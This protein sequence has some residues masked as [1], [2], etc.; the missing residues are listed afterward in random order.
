MCLSM[1]PARLL[2]NS[3]SNAPCLDPF[4]ETNEVGFLLVPVVSRTEDRSLFVQGR[5]IVGA[6]IRPTF[7]EPSR[8]LGARVRSRALSDRAADKFPNLAVAPGN[9]VSAHT[10]PPVPG[11]PRRIQV[12]GA[13]LHGP[14]AQPHP[15]GLNAIAPF[16][17][18]HD[19]PAR[20]RPPPVPFAE[21]LPP[22]PDSPLDTGDS[23]I[24]TPQRRAFP[25]LARSP[26]GTLF[27]PPPYGPDEFPLFPVARALRNSREMP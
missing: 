27:L 11:T 23:P 3:C 12:S 22:R 1:W 25:C 19:H 13:V 10:R 26:P 15:D 4:M 14:F 8:A 9:F 6:G 17:E 21:S 18:S 24:Q 16:P 5:L 20:S 7:S 2:K